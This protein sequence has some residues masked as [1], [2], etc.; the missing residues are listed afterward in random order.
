MIASSGSVEAPTV[1]I[2]L[3]SSSPLREMDQ[4]ETISFGQVDLLVSLVKSEC[5]MHSQN[6]CATILK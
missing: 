6:F 5:D 3:L 1:M 4:Q 2:R